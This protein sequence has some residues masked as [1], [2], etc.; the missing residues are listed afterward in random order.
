MNTGEELAISAM[1]KDFK[2]LSKIAE[3]AEKE[4]DEYMSIGTE[5]V[6]IHNEFVEIV[7]SGEH[8]ASTLKKLD[9]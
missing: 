1:K 7:K 2:R 9:A 8:S 5:M 3:K 4:C 6:D